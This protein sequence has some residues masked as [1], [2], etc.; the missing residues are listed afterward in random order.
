MVE[1]IDSGIIRN[2]EAFIEEVKKHYKVDFAILFGSI[3][4]GS[5]HAD[6]DID[7]AIVSNDVRN[8]FLD[9]LEMAKL[10]WDIDLRIEVHPINTV[11]YINNETALINEIRNTG[12]PLFAT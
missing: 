9:G 8:N 10:R 12:I 7:V 11:E 3:V 4:K 2:V 5:S 1:R 6:S